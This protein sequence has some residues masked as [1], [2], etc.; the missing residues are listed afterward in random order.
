MLQ[1]LAPRTRN[2]VTAT[3]SD[4]SVLTLSHGIAVAQNDLPGHTSFDAFGDASVSS[5]T[6]Y[7]VWRG[8]TAIK[9]GPVALGFQAS[10]VSSSASDSAAGA[11]LRK[12]KVIY[13]D[14]AGALQHEIVTLNGTTPVLTVAEDVMFVECAH[15]TEVG[16][17]GATAVGNITISNGATVVNAVGV[18]SN[19][20]TSMHRMVPA[21]YRMFI[22]AWSCSSAATTS[23]KHVVFR[24]R[25]TSANG[26]NYPGTFIQR[27]SMT[28]LDTAMFVPFEVPL[29]IPSL[30][31]V[32]VTAITAGATA[33]TSECNAWLEP[34]PTD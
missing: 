4:N 31:E 15:A 21:G 8:P 14:T 12:L 30:A 24:L 26:D 20:C 2:M 13:L 5:A 17:Y 23:A 16:A 29:V 19:R 25:T 1:G 7:D 11:G 9:P 28:C 32:K 22:T 6:T 18:G 33:A 34:N 10:I 3:V 27:R